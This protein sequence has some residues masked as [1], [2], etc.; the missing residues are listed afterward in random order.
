MSTP[1]EAISKQ[2][3]TIYAAMELMQSELDQ[4]MLD[5]DPDAPTWRDVSILACMADHANTI[6]AASEEK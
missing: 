2:I 6:I 4:A 1:A 3:A 5:I